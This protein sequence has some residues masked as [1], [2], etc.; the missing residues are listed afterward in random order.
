MKK[1]N[2]ILVIFSTF[3]NELLDE[4]LSAENFLQKSSYPKMK[5]EIISKK[6][7]IVPKLRITR[8]RFLKVMIRLKKALIKQ[9]KV[10][11]KM[12]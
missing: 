4:V 8:R 3:L 1:L 2:K 5:L 12:K 10:V 6:E 11:M 9:L 7:K